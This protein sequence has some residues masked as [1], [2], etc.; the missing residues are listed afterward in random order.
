MERRLIGNGRE[1]AAWGH[2]IGPAPT[3][4]ASAIIIAFL[5]AALV[6]AAGPV[7]ETAVDPVTVEAPRRPLGDPLVARG[8]VLVRQ[9]C[10][11]CHSV[12][13]T[14]VSIYAHAPP[15]RWMNR[16]AP[17]ALQRA[18]AQVATGDHYAMPQVMLTTADAEAI[19]AFVRAFANADAMTQ[20]TMSLSPCVMRVC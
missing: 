10:A 11:G 16:L 9:R 17:N 3:A 14:G 18:S 12:G 6:G 2:D 4:E 1:D 7:A 19:S 5:L 15:F 20:K 8:Q 13:A